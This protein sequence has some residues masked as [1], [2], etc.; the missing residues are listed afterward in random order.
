MR[1][2]GTLLSAAG[3]ISGPFR[4]VLVALCT[5]LGFVGVSPHPLSPLLLTIVHIL[6][7]LALLAA[8]GLAAFGETANKIAGYLTA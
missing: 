7:V 5:V 3:S 8:V 6:G 4:W 2:Y 1:M